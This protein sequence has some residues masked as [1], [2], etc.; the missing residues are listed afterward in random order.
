LTKIKFKDRPTKELIKLLYKAVKIEK[1]LFAES[2]YVGMFAVF[3]ETLLKFAYK[4]LVKDKYNINYY[5]LLIGYPNKG[6]HADIKLWKIAN[7]KDKNKREKKLQN[8]RQEY[9][10][11]IQDKD[12][13]FK[14]LGENFKTIKS[15]AVLYKKSL[16]P[17]NKIK[18]A[19]I[20]RKKRGQFVKENLR[21]FPFAKPLFNKVLTIAQEYAK[22]RDSRPFYYKGNRI[23]RAI[24]FTIAKRF[25]ITKNPQDIF[26]VSLDELELYFENKYNL[27]QLKA[28]ISKRKQNYNKYYKSEPKINIEE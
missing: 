7:I 14:T 16:N 8:W 12:I 18:K 21:H 15:L 17:N 27:K 1:K 10:Y 3:S 2:I 26:F 24:L 13:F 23:I 25:S 20:R 5:E 28:N 6:I 19:K 22:I 4:Y 9:G 11:R